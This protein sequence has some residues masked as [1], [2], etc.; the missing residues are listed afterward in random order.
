MANHNDIK[1][2]WPG[3]KI[4]REIG[5][6]T[7][8][9]VYEIERKLLSRTE[10]A[11]LKVI[12][13]PRDETEYNMMLF[14][15]GYDKE[16]VEK[17]IKSQ[18]RRV[19]NE[20]AVMSTMRGISN[21]VT[22]DDYA[23]EEKENG[24]YTVFIRM[25]L[26]NSLQSLI[27]EKKKAKESFTDEDVIRL[28]KDICRALEVCEKQNIIH[29][30]IKPGNILISDMGDY[31]L[32]DFGT[33]R[34][35]DHTTHATYAGTVSFMAPEVYNRQKYGKTVD[36][37]SL[38]LV[39]YWLL[40]GYRMP[41]VSQNGIPAAEE[42]ADAEARRTGGEVL[43]P[44]CNAGKE[45]SD[46]ILRACAYR[47]EDRYSSA[48]EMLRDLEKVEDGTYVIS[49]SRTEYEKT[50][51]ETDVFDL[52]SEKTIPLIEINDM[53]AVEK[54]VSLPGND[55][56]PEII[57]PETLAMYGDYKNP[58]QEER[59]RYY[60]ADPKEKL[61]KKN[62]EPSS[63]S[64]RKYIMIGAA[65]VLLICV[66]AAGIKLLAGSGKSDQSGSEQTPVN[67][68]VAE[69]S[70][71]TEEIAYDP[72]A[73][74][75]G[76]PVS[77]S[78]SSF[79]E[80]NNKFIYKPENV[81]DGDYSTSWSEGAPGYGKGE[82]ITVVFDNDG[83]MGA[84]RIRNGHTKSEDLYYDNNRIEDAQLRFEDGTVIAFTLQDDYESDQ[85]VIFPEE[86]EG[87]SLTLVIQSAYHGNKYN[88]TCISEL[89][90]VKADMEYP[91]DMPV[92][93]ASAVE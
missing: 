35:I 34:S 30:D 45:L 37:Y 9:A 3:W 76:T 88:N 77:A 53:P 78:A 43:P 7:F 48:S 87:S 23:Y 40:N 19:E 39:M 46:V 75:D 92:I 13:I 28:G 72:A 79:L 50:E 1:I 12:S 67:Q 60:N 41:F 81:I 38:G 69:Q 64:G 84:V 33:A 27:L 63:P 2:P 58:E 70:E 29:R 25:E 5:H 62:D 6:G 51:A 82:N 85:I 54:T 65:A 91:E 26:M 89:G 4:V 71:Q 59:L 10:K 83:T 52:A 66:L 36:I 56:E 61:V 42:L 90:L 11:A 16:A 80:V 74:A 14:A 47:I 20:Y 21:I 8:G 15:S 68:T 49:D 73:C 24:G 44:P 32:G 22:C 55:P 17:S 86:K 57:L 93:Y 18:L 31:N